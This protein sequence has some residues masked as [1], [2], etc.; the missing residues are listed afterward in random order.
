MEPFDTIVLGLGAVG[1]A[2]V[3]QLAK[4]RKRVL[5]IDQFSPP[6]AYGSSHGDTRIT[7]LA[8]GEGPQYTP[9][10]LRSHEIWRELENTTGNSLLTTNGGLIIS[11]N[12]KSS[13][14]HVEEFF[15]NTL[16][17]AKRFGIAH[18]VLDAREI[19]RRFPAFN[20]AHDEV[21]YYE[22]DAGF[23]RPEA[24]IRTQLTLAAAE[25]ATIHSDEQVTGFDASDRAV[26]VTTTHGTYVCDNVIV[27]AGPWLPQLVGRDIAKLLSVYRQ[28]LCWFDTQDDASAFSPQR[29]PVFIWELQRKPQ[30][31]YGFPAIDGPGGGI[32]IA[33]ETYGETTT[34]DTADRDVDP[35][36]VAAM[37]VDYVAPYIKGVTSQCQRTA[38]CLYTVTPDFA[39]VIDRH[40]HSHR[41]IIA[42]PCSGHGFKHSAAIGEALA[43]WII[44]GRSRVELAAFSL[45]RFG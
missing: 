8:I 30:G 1:S 7:R 34:A 37:Y 11:S 29:F 41:V 4:R 26:T 18:E 3:Y 2:A 23:L 32:K 31:V 6:H 5:G 13:I 38:T 9:L 16:A 27:C 17:A 28:V 21:G 42:S 12:T 36:E 15:A 24:C 19:R 39:F 33:T 22:R 45:G 35:Q 43:Q 25:G 20:V 44:D 40:P 14:T 10:A